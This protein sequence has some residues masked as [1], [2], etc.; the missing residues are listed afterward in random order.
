MA[1]GDSVKVCDFF[2]QPQV[3]PLTL[4]RLAGAATA[5]ILCALLS[6][7]SLSPI[8]AAPS[9]SPS[10]AWPPKQFKFA[11]LCSGFLPLDRRLEEWFSTPLAVPALHV[12][13]RQ[14]VV[15]ISGKLRSPKAI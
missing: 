4:F 12:L 9:S 6:Q 2:L 7:P 10:V 8:F 5:T 15:A 13:G 14:D 11:I 1:S 3:I